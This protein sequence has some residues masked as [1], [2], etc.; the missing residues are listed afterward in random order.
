LK[1]RKPNRL[2][3]A[4]LS[5]VASGAADSECSEHDRADE[6]ECG[7][8]S[9]NLESNGCA[10]QVASISAITLTISRFGGIAKSQIVLRRGSD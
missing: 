10:H 6:N 9:E 7:A 8:R 2:P 3:A 1:V 5:T 4:R